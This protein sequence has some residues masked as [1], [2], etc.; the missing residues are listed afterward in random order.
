[1]PSSRRPSFSATRR[2]GV[3]RGTIAASSRCS[4]QRLE[5][6][7]HD[8]HDAFGHVP[9]AGERLVDPVADVAIWNGPRCTLPRLTSPAKRP[10]ARNRPNPYAASKCRC[11]SHAPQRARNASRSSAG[12]ALPGSGIGSHRSSHSRHRIA[13]SRHASQSSARSGRSTTRGADELG[14]VSAPPRSRRGSPDPRARTGRRARRRSTTARIARR[15]TLALRVFGSAVGEAHRRGLERRTEVL[16]DAR[17]RAPSRNASSASTPGRDDDEHPERLALQ[18]V[19]NT[20][21]GRL[22][23]RGMR[24]EH[25][26]DLGRTEPLAR[27]LDRV[28]GAA[29]QEPLAVVGDAREV[30]VPPHVGPAR[31]V[32][33]EVALA[34]PAT[35]RGSSPATASC[36]RARRPRRAPAGRRRR[37]RRPP[38]RARARRAS[39]ATAA[40]TTCGDRKHAPTSVPPEMLITGQRPPPTTSKYQRHGASFHGSPVDARTR[41]DDRSC[42][43]TGVVA[44]RHQRADQRRRHT[45]DR[46]AM[47]LDERP[48]PVGTGVVG[49]AV[50]EHQ[51]PAVG[52]RADDLPRPHDPADVGEPEQPL[53]RVAGPSGT[54]P[55]RRS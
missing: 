24:D 27:E 29:V 48:Q 28:V 4:A 34:D 50:V 38:C 40:A 8:Q 45:E 14:H 37:T 12:S 18:L 23:H 46:D 6:V 20:D 52:E 33:L 17:A 22:H 36:T 1:M 19:G 9:V 7:A 30:A 47:A 54:R 41:S 39:T 11:R 53:A 31:P 16:G 43:R 44:V 25:G 42:A 10:S 2:L 15:S 21:R 13:T 26:L 51:R 32:G 49:R 55:L 5:R 3:L 35:G